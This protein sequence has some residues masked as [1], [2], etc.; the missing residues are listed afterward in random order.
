[1]LQLRANLGAGGPW[2]P[3]SLWGPNERAL[4]AWCVAW[5]WHGMKISA[6]FYFT[7]LLAPPQR[8]GGLAWYG[9]VLAAACCGGRQRPPRG[10]TTM[11][12][13]ERTRSLGNPLW[14]SSDVL[15]YPPLRHIYRKRATRES[16]RERLSPSLL[17]HSVSPFFYFVA[18][19]LPSVCLFVYC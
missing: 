2:G 12:K 13:P 18:S 19:V 4:L 8:C 11:L 15:C 5:Q 17:R 3:H 6:L 1:M 14:V 10:R 9:G 16:L 7:P